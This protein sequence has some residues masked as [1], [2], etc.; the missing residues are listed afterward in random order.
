[1]SRD[2]RTFRGNDDIEHGNDALCNR[3]GSFNF[4]CFVIYTNNIMERKDK[5]FFV[6]FFVCLK[7]IN[8]LLKLF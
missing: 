2:T 5:I 8:E 6:C 4:I 1:M 7:W 3:Y